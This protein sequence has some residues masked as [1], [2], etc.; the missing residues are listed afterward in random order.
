MPESAPH[1][2]PKV[3]SDAQ[4]GEY[5]ASRNRPI[6]SYEAGCASLL[7]EVSIC[8]YSARAQQET[9]KPTAASAGRA[10]SCSGTGNRAMSALPPCTRFRKRFAAITAPLP[11][12]K[13]TLRQVS[14]FRIGTDRPSWEVWQLPA[15]RPPGG[16]RLASPDRILRTGK[17]R[18]SSTLIA[19]WE[20]N[21]CRNEAHCL[22][23]LAHGL[24]RR[25]CG[26]WLVDFRRAPGPY[27][28]LNKPRFSPPNQ[29]FG[30][31]WASIYALMALA[32]WQILLLPPL[33]MRS[34]AFCCSLYSWA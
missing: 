6:F 13:P 11:A 28:S 5:S 8:R 19:R 7:L 10:S 14:L 3:P 12:P 21:G 32:V 26:G 31:A 16:F 1:S 17:R 34:K 24:L 29:V 4:K 23:G 25:C 9:L 22:N 2:A 30:P 27:L 18:I 20:K 15:T 33:R